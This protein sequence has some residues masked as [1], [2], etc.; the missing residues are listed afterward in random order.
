MMQDLVIIG[1]GG[2]GREVAD[3]VDA[4]N[5]VSP[6]WRLLGHLDD[7]PGAQDAALVRD[8]GRPVLGGVDHLLA[9]PGPSYVIGIGSGAARRSI[10]RRL[11]EA[12]ASAA[13]LVHPAATVGARCRL[14]EG[15]VVCAGAHITTNVTVGRHVHVNLGS[16]VGHDA[17]LGDYVTLNPLVAVSG[18]VTIG[19]GTMLGTHSAVLQGITVGARSVVGAAA[20]VVKDVADDVVVKGVPAR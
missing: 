7:D 14:G 11:S 4:I 2:F 10:D 6:T 19:E 17:T 5:A 13:T 1:C 20:C 9:D 3:V 8:A 12:G 18:H 16:T 15:V